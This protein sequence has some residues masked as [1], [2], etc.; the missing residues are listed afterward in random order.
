VIGYNAG[1][2]RETVIDDKTGILL[3]NRTK[4]SL[5][6]ATEDLEIKMTMKYF[7]RKFIAEH[8]KQF[9]KEKYLKEMEQWVLENVK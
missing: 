1:G 9:S 3:N 6:K 2:V 5:S 4:E 8:A 7:D